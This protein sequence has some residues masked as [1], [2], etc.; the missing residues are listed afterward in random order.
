MEKTPN[1]LIKISD[2]IEV[3]LE[4]EDSLAGKIQNSKIE[5]Q[6]Q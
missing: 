1:G 4:A 5:L 3:I 2:F 6:E